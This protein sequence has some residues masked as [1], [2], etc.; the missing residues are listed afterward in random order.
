MTGSM[1][2]ATTCLR[3]LKYKKYFNL[4]SIEREIENYGRA[5]G[6]SYCTAKKTVGKQIVYRCH[7]KKSM[8]CKA[9][10]TVINRG[11]DTPYD[12]TI[13]T[14]HTHPSIFEPTEMDPSPY[15]IDPSQLQ[16]KPVLMTRR[17]QIK[18]R[19]FQTMLNLLALAS[20]STTIQE[21]RKI[22]IYLSLY[23][24]E[25]GLSLLEENTTGLRLDKPMAKFPSMK[26][27]RN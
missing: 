5:I 20:R 3:N 13:Y 15:D 17:M 4:L 19:C 14:R 23:V 25:D 21:Y 8:K 9:S 10:F 1:E 18:R 2:I 16:E 11:G 26:V 22:L 27:P 24:S 7:L 12:I 6:I